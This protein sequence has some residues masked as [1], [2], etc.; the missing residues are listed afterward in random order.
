MSP[1]PTVFVIDDDAAM[2]S[3]LRRLISSVGLAVETYRSATE[4]LETFDAG[5]PGCIVLDVRM[6][7]MSG[8][9]LQGKLRHDGHRIPVIIITAHADVAMAVG[10]MKSGA[11]D[12]IE[13]P[14][15]PQYL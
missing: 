7:E 5:A 4:F 2:R 8:L 1:E 3:S 6:P 11:V 12:F 14:F 10:S 13:K 15:R 9:E